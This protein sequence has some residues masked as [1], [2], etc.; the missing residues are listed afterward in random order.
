M[1]KFLTKLSA[2][3]IL[4]TIIMVAIT[5]LTANRYWNS[6][7][8]YYKSKIDISP[9]YAISIVLGSSHAFYGING[10]LITTNCYN[11]S[12]ISQSFYEDFAILKNVNQKTKVNLVIV[13]FSLFSNYL[14]LENTPRDG[15]YR[16][17]FDYE[18]AYDLKYKKN[19][20]YLNNKL[21]IYGQFVKNYFSAKS[22]SSQIDSMGNLTDLCTGKNFPIDDSIQSFERHW[23][24]HDFKKTAPYLDSIIS[25]C[26]TKD[27]KLLIIV[28]PF[29]KGY[30]DQIQKKAPE[31]NDFV[32]NLKEKSIGSFV[33]V[34]ARDFIQENETTNFRDADHLSACG[35]DL[36]SR[37]LGYIATSFNSQEK[38]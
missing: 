2:Y 38:R 22:A 8:P 10:N 35:R 29:S 28:P 1:K 21:G 25:Y 37:Y 26:K 18:K 30:R 36:F 19:Y 32:K 4:T 11:L 15:E 7:V 6:R 16:R 13:P 34:D 3:L 12:S 23:Q 5:M 14:S 20:R 27:I 33:M 9:N 17:I 24:D 31:F